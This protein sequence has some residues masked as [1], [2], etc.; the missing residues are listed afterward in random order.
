MGFI[1]FYSGYILKFFMMSEINL[2]FFEGG[3][4]IK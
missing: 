2:W 1:Y 3:I 4:R